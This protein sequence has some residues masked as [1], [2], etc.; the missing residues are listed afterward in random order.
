MSVQ[1]VGDYVAVL[2]DCVDA[3]DLLSV[4]DHLAALY[5]IFLKHI[6]QDQEQNDVLGQPLH[7]TLLVYLEIHQRRCPTTLFLAI[8]P[9]SR[10]CMYNDKGVLS[11][12]HLRGSRV[13][14]MDHKEL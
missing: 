12:G 8:A 5:G 4:D 10:C 3:G 6:S 2:D 11:E 1:C 13:E 9:C 14:A 7:N